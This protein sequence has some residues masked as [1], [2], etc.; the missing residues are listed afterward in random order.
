MPEN[1]NELEGIVCIW[2]IDISVNGQMVH[3]DDLVF[4]MINTNEWNLLYT[5]FYQHEDMQQKKLVVTVRDR[6]VE[7][8]VKWFSLWEGC[9][10]VH[11]SQLS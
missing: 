2:K 8:A 3:N 4:V 11:L 7:E 1:G 9:N 6:K 5:C 10:L